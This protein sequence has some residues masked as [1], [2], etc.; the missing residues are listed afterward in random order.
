MEEEEEEE[1]EEDM[2][3]EKKNVLLRLIC[4]AAFPICCPKNEPGE[5]RG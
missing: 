4:I 1:E 3:K 5:G 2:K